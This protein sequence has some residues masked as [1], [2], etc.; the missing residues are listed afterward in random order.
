MTKGRGRP[1]VALVVAAFL[2]TA[3]GARVTS[4]QAESIA[5]SEASTPTTQVAGAA[6]A[7]SADTVAPA[8]SGTATTVA[9]STPGVTTG[10]PAT[11]L[12]SGGNGGATDVGVTADSIALGQVATLSGPV[13]GL[14]AGSV[15]GSQAAIGYLNSLGG[16]YGR[17]LKMDTRDDQFDTGQNRAQTAD[18]VRKVFA[19]VAGFSVYDDA[20]V[21]DIEATKT[22]DVQVAI[23]DRLVMSP[24]NFAVS[25]ARRGAPTGEF[26]LMK[27]K[28]PDAIAHAAVL[29]GDIPAATDNYKNNR[30]AAE[31]VG[32]KLVYTRAYAATETDFTADVVRMRQAG[33]TFF[34]TNG[35]AKTTGRIASAMAAQNF[36]PIFMAYGSYD[37]NFLALAGKGAEGTYNMTTQAMYLGEDAAFNPELRLMRQWLAKVK[38]G[39]EPDIFTV[40]GWTSVRLFAKALQDAGPKATRAGVT[41][42]LRKIDSWNSYGL[43]PEVGPG[44]KRPAHCYMVTTV[45]NG[46]FE[47]WNS[48]PPGFRCDGTFFWRK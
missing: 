47:R 3:C 9:P 1:F 38:P 21:G 10:G 16:I 17:K 27:S 41:A 29:Y 43:L 7:A 13:P 46:K 37:K 48:P 39:Y 20:G 35:D 23:N 12:P 31:S 33:V 34:F 40:Y 24:M 45:R 18:L 14:F 11:T 6:A 26:E 32:Y 5:T 8:A 28:F 44:P 2:A 22:P 36:K 42:A 25:P 15:V 19:L 30:A 4:Q